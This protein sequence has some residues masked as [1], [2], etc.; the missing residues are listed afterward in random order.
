MKNAVFLAALMLST[1]V[2][3]QTVLAPFTP[4]DDS[5]MWGFINEKGETVIEPTY[6]EVLEFSN[7]GLA[8][9]F[10][11]SRWMIID[12]QNQELKTEVETFSPVSYFGFGKRGFVNGFVVIIQSKLQGAMDVNGKLVHPFKYNFISDF[13]NGFA[14][15]K[16]GK[17]FFILDKSGNSQ[18]VSDVIDLKGFSEGLAPFRAKDK[19]FGFMDPTGKIVIPAQYKTVGYFSNGLAWVKTEEGTVGY[20]DKSGKFVI[21]PVFV[22]AKEF[23]TKLGI[24]RVK[25]GEEWMYV[26]KKD[27]STFSIEGASNFGDF[28]DGR[29]FARKGDLYGFI[30]EN[31]KWV[32][33]PKYTKVRDFHGGYAPVRE[34]ELWGV[35]D[36]NGNMVCEPKF[37]DIK[38]FTKLK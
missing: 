36:L 15:A 23:D 3:A 30:D 20:V 14:S 10:N 28:H 24:A 6:K 16:I 8:M 9:V 2:K 12:K 7:D 1:L 21:D 35:V 32:I 18:E 38:H 33:E 19:L 22:N 34:G 5:R 25:K 27:G 17:K 31:G 29:A 11:G 26:R 37:G 4:A 13:E